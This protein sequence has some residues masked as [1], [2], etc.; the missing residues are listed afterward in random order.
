MRNKLANGS[1]RLLGRA[2]LL[3]LLAS[4]YGFAAEKPWTLPSDSARTPGW[5]LADLDGDRVADL[6]DAGPGLRE[7]DSYVH[8]V[9][10]SL[11]RSGSA[12]FDIHGGSASIRLSFRDIDG[13]HDR[14]L[15]VFEPSSASPV[16][17][18]L[19]DGAGHFTEGDLKSYANAIGRSGPPSLNTTYVAQDTLA[20]FSG[21]HLSFHILPSALTPVA[22]SGVAAFFTTAVPY[23]TIRDAFAPRGPPSLL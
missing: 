19:N 16:A 22:S 7:G 20:A 8:K 9:Q 2:G 3:V 18:W 6:A 14:D 4:C 1:L 11:S 12:S 23:S 17:V 10:V 13:D 5:S 15:V 21:D